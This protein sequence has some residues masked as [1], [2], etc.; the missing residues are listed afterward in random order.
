[1][2]KRLDK[3]LRAPM[4]NARRVLLAYHCPG[5]V[6]EL[7]N[8]IERAVVVSIGEKITR[9]NLRS[10]LQGKDIKNISDDV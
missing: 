7:E 6:R 5:N 10:H 4:D 9:T 8:V 1:M 3:H 2:N